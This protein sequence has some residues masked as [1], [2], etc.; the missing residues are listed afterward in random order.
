MA[1]SSGFTLESSDGVTKLQAA[2]SYG[3]SPTLS[4]S[5]TRLGISA[6]ISRTMLASG[7]AISIGDGIQVR[8][9][10]PGLATWV[11]SKGQ[12]GYILQENGEVFAG[13]AG[14]GSR[15]MISKVIA[16]LPQ[17]VE[18]C[19]DLWYAYNL[20]VL[21]EAAAVAVSITNPEIAPLDVLAVSLAYEDATNAYNAVVEF[22]CT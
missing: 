16:V 12:S 6:Q 14:I 10:Q 13:G 3:T 7:Q 22:H 9:A 1:A 2:F 8:M 11:N 18:S 21:A 15:V 19:S 20:A 5:S 17:I 4:L